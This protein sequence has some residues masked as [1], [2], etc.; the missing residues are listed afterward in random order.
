MKTVILTT[1]L[2]WSTWMEITETARNSRVVKTRQ[3]PIQAET[4]VSRDL[5]KSL[6]KKNHKQFTLI[7]GKH[8]F[9]L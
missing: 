4:N 2:L 1:L 8:W 5:I 3:G 6:Y 9:L 7:L